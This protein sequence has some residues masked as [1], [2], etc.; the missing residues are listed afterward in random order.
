VLALLTDGDVLFILSFAFWTVDVTHRVYFAALTNLINREK[1]LPFLFEF[2]IY[3]TI[4]R[5]MS[6]IFILYMV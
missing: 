6:T 5:I 1:I 2:T 3:T 4:Y